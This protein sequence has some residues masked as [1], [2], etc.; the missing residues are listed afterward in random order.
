MQIQIQ[1]KTSL[2]NRIHFNNVKE[3]ALENTC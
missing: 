3:T 1:K 2:E